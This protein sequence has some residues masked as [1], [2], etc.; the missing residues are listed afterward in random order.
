M[1]ENPNDREEIGDLPEESVSQEAAE[2]V[3]GGAVPPPPSGP[4]PTPYPN[5][6]LSTDPRLIIPCI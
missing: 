4:V 3:K 5:L 6:K 2:E 1:T